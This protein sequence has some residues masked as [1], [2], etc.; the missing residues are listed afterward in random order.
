MDLMLPMV[1][2]AAV[3]GVAVLVMRRPQRAMSRLGRHEIAAT[4]PAAGSVAVTRTAILTEK[5]RVG[6]VSKLA[7][8]ISPQEARSK[9]AKLLDYAGNPMPVGTYLLV[10]AM[11]LFALTPLSLIYFY[12]DRGLTQSGIAFMV[13][14][15]FAIPQLPTMYVKRIARK[16]AKEVERAMPD[17]L[18]LLVVCVEGGLSLDGGLQ[19]VA[20]RTKGMLAVEIGRLLTEIGAG[21]PRREALLS[22][23]GRNQSESLGALCTTVN[24]ADKT[25][26]SIATTLRTLSE[27]LR[28]KRRQAAETQARKAPIK[29]MPFIVFFMLPALFIVIL[30]PVGVS[31]M[32][33]FG[34][35]GA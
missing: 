17:A 20:L 11:F 34:E 13:M 30:G 18:D 32:N 26:V 29:M 3:F 9:A 6:Q 12:R 5:K 14:C 15:I 23:M 10:R 16:R 35:A 28:T 8:R 1:V 19:Q 4:T 24:Q 7:D 25:G 22:M 27:T 21:L 33:F 2:F 31:M